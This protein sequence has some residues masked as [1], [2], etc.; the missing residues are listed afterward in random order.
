MPVQLPPIDE[1][2]RIAESHGLG[3]DDT[4]L[5]SFQSLIGEWLVG[6]ERVEHLPQQ[7]LPSRYPRLAGLRATP[8]DNAHNAWYWRCD[9]KGAEGGLLAGKT[10]AIKDSI[11][12]GGVP[13]MN[14][15]A[16]LEG[17]TPE[18]DA[19][20][21]TRILD[22]GGH[23]LGK[24]TCEDLCLSAGSHN[25]RTGMVPNPWDRE[26]SAGGSSSGSAA[27]VASG[28]VDLALGGDQAG[29]IRAPAS[30][31]GI[32]GHKPTYGLVPYTGAFP[33]EMTL[34]HLG[35]MTRTVGEAATL[36][37]VL[38]GRDE[39]DPRQPSA[40]PTQPYSEQYTDV[41]ARLRV[42]VVQEGFEWG[43]LSDPAVDQAVREAAAEF[44]ALGAEVSDVS[45][46]IHRNGVD[47]WA[48][49]ANEGCADMMVKGNGYGTNHDG[50]FPTSLIDAFGRGRSSRGRDLSLMVKATV[51]IAEYLKE[52]YHGRYYAQA[53][54]AA[55]LL[56]AAY[57]EV[58]ETAD[59]LVLPTTPY[60]ATKLPT[61]EI[62]LAE[63]VALST[64][65]LP[66]TS[67]FNVTGHPAITI[68]CGKVGGLPV[69]M[70]LVGR[71]WDDLRVLQAAYA[72]EQH[73]G[74]FDSL[75]GRPG[76]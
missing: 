28:E 1:L 39:F 49:I 7:S 29:S 74:G 75:L 14:G 15:S 73:V 65:M 9:I 27:L 20:V 25:S 76:A 48:V 70:M 5:Q 51:L 68:P 69:G 8:P 16:L 55:P 40:V 46:P 50:F 6:Y 42:A 56:R 53:R 38:A 34:D 62:S 10:V 23:I 57:D 59:V 44:V 45:I 24:A 11:A 33:I 37:E 32:V 71:R 21:V 2:R 43:G 30:W 12:V 64:A 66:N 52:R 41:P 60:T 13:M 26:R 67:P 36:L 35:P 58:L 19:T 47:I 54:N 31:C 61:S 72:Y 22:A 17:Y 4:D 3:L 63:S 18:F